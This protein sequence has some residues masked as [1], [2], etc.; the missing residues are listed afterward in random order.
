MQMTLLFAFK[1]FAHSFVHSEFFILRMLKFNMSEQ[2]VLLL[3]FQYCWNAV[4]HF[5]AFFSIQNTKNIDCLSNKF[6]KICCKNIY[7]TFY[8]K[9]QTHLIDVYCK[10]YRLKLNIDSIFILVCNKR[11]LF[12]KFVL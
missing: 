10:R 9:F 7:S 5:R 1:R 2:F 3:D 8:Y 6:P 11:Y 12:I 4:V